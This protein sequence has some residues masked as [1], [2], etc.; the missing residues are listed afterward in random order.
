MK[1][2][3]YNIRWAG[4]FCTCTVIYVEISI[5]LS[6]SSTSNEQEKRFFDLGWLNFCITYQEWENWK[7]KNYS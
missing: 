1:R 5:A 6:V 7:F 4:L 2:P 3:H